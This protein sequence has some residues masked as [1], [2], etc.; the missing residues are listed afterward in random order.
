M[1]PV[2]AGTGDWLVEVKVA[3]DIYLGVAQARCVGGG[4]LVADASH[5]E[6]HRWCFI[7]P[8]GLA[9]G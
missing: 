6:S 7:A 9:V 4:G 2:Q 1:V 3:G 8:A 5:R